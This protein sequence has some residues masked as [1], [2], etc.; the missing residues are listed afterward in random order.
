[1]QG[2]GQ[3]SENSKGGSPKESPLLKMT[4]RA[5]IESLLF[6]IVLLLLASISFFKDTRNPLDRAIFVEL[7]G[8]G[9]SGLKNTSKRPHMKWQGQSD[10]EGTNE[11]SSGERQE[12][13]E[14]EI[15]LNGDNTNQ[16]ENKGES[17]GEPS[18][19]EAP[20]SSGDISFIG[21]QSSPTGGSLIAIPF[22]G[23]AEYSSI[24]SDIERHIIY[25]EIARRRG[26]KGT[27]LAGFIIDQKGMPTEIKIIKSSNY[28]VLDKEVIRIIKK[29]SPYRVKNIKVEVPISFRLKD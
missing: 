8:Q 15:S 18:A 9:E 25:P 10:L 13:K 12:G 28:E 17:F 26:L 19:P 1:M 16:K 5:F 21:G 20:S 3:V 27:V 2:L 6:H 4:K 11:Q 14:E 22:A 7:K 29:A 24:R 23:E